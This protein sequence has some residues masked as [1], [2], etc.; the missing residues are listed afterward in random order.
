MMQ[1][2]FN[3]EVSDRY[4]LVG[5]LAQYILTEELCCITVLTNDSPR[6]VRARFV[7]TS[8]KERERLILLNIKNNEISQANS[9]SPTVD[10]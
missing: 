2:T 7:Q 9:R 5:N 10:L 3:G 1:K 6:Y 4:R 8:E